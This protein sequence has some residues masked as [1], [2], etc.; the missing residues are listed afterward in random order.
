VL[1]GWGGQLTQTTWGATKESGEPPHAG[2]AGG[3]SIWFRW[4]AT[5]DGTLVLS[6][7]G[8]D[9]D[10]LLAVYRES[11]PTLTLL[12]ANDDAPPGTAAAMFTSLVTVPVTNGDTL[13]VAVDGKKPAGTGTFP[14]AGHLHLT[15]NLP[16]DGI[17]GAEPVLAGVSV[18]GANIGATHEGGEPHH[19]GDT[20]STASVWYRWT[21][22][23]TGANARIQASGSRFLCVATYASQVAA[24]TMWDLLPIAAAADDAGQ[25]VDYTFI[26]APGATY[27]VAVDGLSVETTC[28]PNGQCWYTT[29]TGTFALT[30][31]M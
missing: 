9:F 28:S 14:G 16:N 25:P 29:P 11:G 15:W 5:R 20:F 1:P 31:T 30:L 10:T 21:A 19:C 7:S 18:A 3:S 24:P 13:L 12:A 8:S 2:N 26:A 17:A 22:P 27:W 4:T 23:A 6:T